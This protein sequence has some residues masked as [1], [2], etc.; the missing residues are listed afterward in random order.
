MRH[1]KPAP[2]YECGGPRVTRRE[3]KLSVGLATPGCTGPR[4]YVASSRALCVQVPPGPPAAA[5]TPRH[6]LQVLSVEQDGLRVEYD[7]GDV[8]LV[9]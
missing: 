1:T 8:E 3:V 7:N 9:R 6:C 5:N 4:V 2:A